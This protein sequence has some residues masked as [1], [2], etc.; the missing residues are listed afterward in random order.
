MLI[1]PTNFPGT[2]S[3]Y[4]YLTRKFNPGDYKIRMILDTNF[5]GY[6]SIKETE[7][8]SKYF[9]K[10]YENRYD[11]PRPHWAHNWQQHENM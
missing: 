3:Y 6:K 4:W 9:K 1:S 10:I 11:N 2:M 5:K 8:N 7:K